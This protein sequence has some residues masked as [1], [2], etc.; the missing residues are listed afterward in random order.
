[1]RSKHLD[2]RGR[3]KLI[4]IAVILVCSVLLVSEPGISNASVAHAVFEAIGFAL[5]L[6]CVGGRL[7]C[8]LYIGGRKNDEL[9]AIGPFSMTR[10]PLYF[11]ST[12][13]AVGVGMTFGS[14]LVAAALGIVAYLIFRATIIREAAHLTAIFGTAYQ[15]YAAA[16]P[17]FWP[18]PFL[19]ADKPEWLFMPAA[20]RSTFRDGLFFFAIAPAVELLELLQAADV[21]PVFFKIY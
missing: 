14:L 11:F 2:Q 10:N 15:T 13:G 5:V 19:Y 3:L 12:I 4:Q 16:T 20:L 1:M 9:I 21:M 18:N 17:R 8:I 7:W 6:A